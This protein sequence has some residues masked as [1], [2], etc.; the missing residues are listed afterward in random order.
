MKNTMRRKNLS[1]SSFVKGLQ[2]HKALYL[3]MFHPA[4][5]DK[6]SEATQALFDSG[7]EIGKLATSLFP[8]GEDFSPFIP[9]QI[10]KVLLETRWLIKQKSTIYEAGFSAQNL[11]CFVDILVPNVSSAREVSSL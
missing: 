8:G 6:I 3:K 9:G 4:L 11:L 2:C 7:T 10:G 1:K 5:E